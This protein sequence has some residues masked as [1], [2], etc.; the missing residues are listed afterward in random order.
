MRPGTSSEIN[1]KGKFIKEIK[2]TDKLDFIKIKYFCT[3]KDITEKT[4]QEVK[5]CEKTSANRVS[6]K[7]LCPQYKRPL[8]T[9]EDK[10][11]NFKWTKD[12]NQHFTN[13]IHR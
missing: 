5:F 13:K 2:K 8:T 10:E 6:E 4:K 7:N 3:S 9:K 11:S 1:I 12:L